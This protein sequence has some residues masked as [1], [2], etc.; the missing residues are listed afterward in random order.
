MELLTHSYFALFLITSLGLI[1]GKVTIRGISLDVSA[2]I[3]VALVFGHFGIVI[4]KEIQTIGLILFIYSIG[5][6]SGPVFFDA[7]KKDG[8]KMAL[9]A[10]IIV[11]AGAIVVVIG[12]QIFQ[13]DD[14]SA[15]G[16]YAGAATSAPALAAGIEATGSELVSI[17][18]GVTY[19]FGVIGV[20][21]LVNLMPRLLK[22]DIKKAEIEY[23]LEQKEV[24][25]ELMHKHFLVKNPNVFGKSI[26]NLK[27]RQ[28]SSANVSRIKHNGLASICTK[29]SVLFENDIIR[30]VGTPEALEKLSILIGPE[31]QE[32]I[33]LD[34]K[35]DVKWILVSNKEVVNKTLAQ[36]NI[37]ENFDATVTRIRRAGIDLTPSG[38]SKI[39]FGDRL[40]IATKGSLPAIS[41]LFGDEEKKLNET[42]FLPI[43][44]GIVIGVLVGI[45]PISFPGGLV[46]TFGLTGGVLIA[47]LVLSRIGKTGPILWS[48]SGTTVQTFRKL[49]LVFFLASIGTN[50]GQTLLE[51]IQKQ[52]VEFLI[53]GLFVTIIPMLI[54]IYFAK[55]VL[56]FNFLTLLGV[57]TGGVT[58]TPGFSA[59][60]SLTES[61]A[62]TLAYATIYP[63][64]MVIKIIMVKVLVFVFAFI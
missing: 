51:S 15:I 39:K 25:P 34:K 52:G 63:I 14:I 43:S 44:L 30:A 36:L 32:Q 24:Y 1:L 61:E 47:S 48:T 22:M 23:K 59:A 50:A 60:S 12:K 56:K 49:G 31:T 20:I 58:S 2:V 33:I 4:P 3:F 21:V 62:P 38:N 6:Q 53:L 10:T 26:F 27:I 35:S 8:V 37:F 19:P 57:I 9:L 42:D 5:I 45:I 13:L 64:A 18:Y 28:I 54:G 55:Y 11:V 40:L 41:K 16:I 46:F 29:E 7:F 17:A